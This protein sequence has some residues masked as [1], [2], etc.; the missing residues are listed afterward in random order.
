MDILQ[1]LWQVSLEVLLLQ[2]WGMPW[3]FYEGSNA[4]TMKK[5]GLDI[6]LGQGLN[7]D[8]IWEYLGE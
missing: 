5:W 7:G 4:M 3:E 6:L 1:L 8:M 2:L